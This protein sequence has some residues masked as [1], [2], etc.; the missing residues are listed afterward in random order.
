MLVVGCSRPWTLP[1]APPWHEHLGD[2]TIKDHA[3][4]WGYHIV[5][6]IYGNI[7]NISAYVREYPLKLWS[8]MNLYGTVPPF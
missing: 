5:M 2:L 8:Y 3:I 1:A 6:V 4:S 7:Y